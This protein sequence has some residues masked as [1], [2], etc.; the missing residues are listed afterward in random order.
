M[1]LCNFQITPINADKFLI[2]NYL[3]NNIAI[4]STVDGKELFSYK[5]KF[6]ENESGLFSNPTI[7]KNGDIAVCFLRQIE[8]KKSNKN[9]CVIDKIAVAKFES[10]I[11]L[12]SPDLKLKSKTNFVKGKS[13]LCFE[14]DNNLYLFVQDGTMLTMKADVLLY[15][16]IMDNLVIVGIAKDFV[17]SP[18][19]HSLVGDDCVLLLPPLNLNRSKANAGIF[20]KNNFINIKQ[21]PTEFKNIESAICD[22]DYIYLLNNDFMLKHKRTINKMDIKTILLP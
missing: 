12:F 21:V 6:E 10:A 8:N 13:E 9:A 17:Y 4:C 22:H 14:S 7:L 16:R 5:S 20:F 3:N 2:T 15:R 11:Y 1:R 18:F 19:L